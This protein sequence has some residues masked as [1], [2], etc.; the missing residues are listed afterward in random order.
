MRCT[1]IAQKSDSSYSISSSSIYSWSS[2]SYRDFSSTIFH[3][4]GRS[5]EIKGAC[6]SARHLRLLTTICHHH[7]SMYSAFHQLSAELPPL[8]FLPFLLTT[9]PG[10]CYHPVIYSSWTALLI[11]N[12]SRQRNFLTLFLF[13]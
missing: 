4:G 10:P 13:S 9:L 12:F 2:N 1:I 8:G 3:Q 5:K 7:R 11:Q 6:W